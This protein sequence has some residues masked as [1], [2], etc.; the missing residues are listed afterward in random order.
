MVPKIRQPGVVSVGSCVHS[1]EVNWGGERGGIQPPSV[2][3]G[4]SELW[5]RSE[6]VDW[7]VDKR[8]HSAI[9]NY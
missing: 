9:G 5:I 2:N 7:K 4:G 3:Q 6:L 8:P 1:Y